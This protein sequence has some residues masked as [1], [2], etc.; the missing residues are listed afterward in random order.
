M[1]QAA[2][3]GAGFSPGRVKWKRFAYIMVPAAAMAAMLV[4][5]TAKGAIGANISVSGKEYLV[6]A[7]ELDGSGFEQFAKYDTQGNGQVPVAVSGI[8]S[9]KLTNLCQ[10]VDTGVGNISIILRAG[11]PGGTPVSASNLIVDAS[12]LAGDATFTNIAIGQD[13]GTLAQGPG[14]GV[15]GQAGTFGEQAGG[16]VI[17]NL[18]QNTWLTT[19]GTFTLPGL[20]LKVS[21]NGATC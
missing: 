15:N 10:A 17:K 14:A 9:A 4:G 7:D 12:S 20:S 3:P 13:A 19:A 2:Q 18:V 6:T 5:L 11:Q 8:G 16:V 1:S 21:T